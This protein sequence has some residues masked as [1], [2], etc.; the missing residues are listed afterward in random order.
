M[1]EQVILYCN[2]PLPPPKKKHTNKTAIHNRTFNI[3]MESLFFNF[4]KQGHL[5][6][7]I[8]P[9]KKPKQNQQAN[10]TKTRYYALFK[11]YTWLTK[12]HIVNSFTVLKSVIIVR[13]IYTLYICTFH[14]IWVQW[15]F[16]NQ[17]LKNNRWSCNEKKRLI[18]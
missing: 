1:Q 2:N 14:Y 17:Y 3:M 8:K 9:K 18:E 5:Y 13:R 4:S 10:K 12:S 7:C 11:R 15:F 6:T 16:W